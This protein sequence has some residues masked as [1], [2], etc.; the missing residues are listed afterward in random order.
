VTL[1]PF[2]AP[3][4]S[5]GPEVQ[6]G[7]ESS[8]WY[9]TRISGEVVLEEQ[10]NVQDN[11]VVE[12][13]TRIGRRTSV[14]HN[15]RIYGATIEESCLIAIAC[16][17]H[18]GAHIGAHS[19]VA[20]NATVPAGM[21]VPPNTLVIGEGRLQRDVRDHEL[22]RIEFGAEEYIRLGREHLAGMQS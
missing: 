17:I 3:T 1:D 6:L 16:T 7:P 5:V 10:A 19:I 20:A 18:S 13:P 8:V 14:G 4:A 22:A 12:G 11:A 21:H 9:G 15:A 2:V